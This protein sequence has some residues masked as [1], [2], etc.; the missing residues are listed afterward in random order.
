MAARALALL[1][2]F[3]PQDARPGE[4]F[5]P[6]GRNSRA[7]GDAV[8]VRVVLLLVSQFF[9]DTVTCSIICPK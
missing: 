6:S 1:G 9:F 3:G 7:R 5:L 4:T 8:S 2:V